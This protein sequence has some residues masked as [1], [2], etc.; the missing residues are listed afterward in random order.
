ML[1]FAQAIGRKRATKGKKFNL[2]ARFLTT[3]L[4]MAALRFVHLLRGATEEQGKEE[5]MGEL[6]GYLPAIGQVRRG[7]HEG[8]LKAQSLF[9]FYY[10]LT[11]F[12]IGATE[13]KRLFREKVDDGFQ[14]F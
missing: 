5:D 1:P 12:V 14:R 3:N 9:G 7:P 13:R 10:F 6:H 11:A 4:E 2:M 8:R